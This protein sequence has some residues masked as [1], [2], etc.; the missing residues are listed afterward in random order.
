MANPVSDID[1]AFGA[2]DIRGIYPTAL[3]EDIAYKVGRGLVV[4]LGATNVMVGRD[5]RLSSP[6][7]AAAVIR[8]I[9]DQGANATDLGMTTTDELYFAVGKFDAPAGIM[10]TASHNPGTYNGLK[11]CREGAIPLSDSTGVFAIRDMVI[12]NDFPTP[13][14]KG[15]VTQRDI[16]AEFVQHAFSFIDKSAIAPM[17]VVAD[18]GNGM[19]GL[20]LPRVFAELPQCALFPL[21]FELDGHFPHHPASP[22]EP[23]NMADLQAEVRA[24]GAD[25]G[26]AFDGDADR[27]FIT[28]ERGDLIDGSTVTATVATSLL[29]KHPGST[30]LYNLISSRSVP[31]AI[32][33]AGG[34]AVRT[35]VGH[36]FIKPQMRAENA[37]FGGE[38]S[39]HFYFR[40]NFYADSGLIAFLHVLELVSQ[41]RTTV[42][43]L[44]APFQTRFASGEINTKVAT[45]A[46]VAQKIQQ[47]AQSF[48]QDAEAQI[49][50]LDGVSVNFP[51]WWFNV[52][53]S[54]TE[55]LLRLNV[56]GDT[57]ELMETGR[58][59]T[60]AIIR[61]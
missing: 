49:D 5:M 17:K 34:K 54:N 44:V 19:A 43:Q 31:E 4:F 56:E 13:T 18:A 42:S 29:R 53:G 1:K 57:R 28:D 23:E 9:T 12:A 30:I 51:H 52:R 58:D 8:G 33:R 14:A 55:P 21:Y 36:S 20:L 2:Y 26:V 24:K 60:L 46:L 50:T 61:N 39:G 45:H 7:L 25:I 47:I 32:E 40:D 38:H 16:L 27:M 11:L 41:E 48:A 6:S 15:Q 35:R 3:N 22:I 10:I 59:R 37:I